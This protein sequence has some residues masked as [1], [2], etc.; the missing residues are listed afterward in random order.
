MTGG[1]ETEPPRQLVP[2]SSNYQGTERW[3]KAPRRAAHVAG[4][5]VS[6]SAVSLPQV[7]S[8]TNRQRI[9]A[10]ISVVPISNVLS[11]CA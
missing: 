6:G 3:L 2:R 10:P 8:A 1:I 4:L 9:A 7:E 5:E 11:G